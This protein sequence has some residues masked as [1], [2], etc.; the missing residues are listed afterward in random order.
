MPL[1]PKAG[2]RAGVDVHDAVVV[3]VGDVQQREPAGQADQVDLVLVAEGEDPAGE[4]GDRGVILA[5]NG[6]D[7]GNVGL[8]GALEAA[9]VGSGADDQGDLDGQPAG[10]AEVDEVL[11]SAAAA[12]EEDGEVEGRGGH[13]I[14]VGLASASGNHLHERSAR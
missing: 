7:L 9:D 8:A 12:G 6:V 5:G 4:F 2:S 13:G 11:Q 10:A 14:D 3:A 1:P